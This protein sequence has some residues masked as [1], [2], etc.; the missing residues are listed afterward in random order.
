MPTVGTISI[1]LEARLAKLESQMDRAARI[2]DAAARRM[3]QVQTQAAKAAES[4]W[5]SASA[6]ITAAA[7]AMGGALLYAAQRAL[8]HADEMG[9]AARA[10][11]IAVEQYSALAYAAQL[12]GVS[13]DQ[14]AAS[15]R[16]FNRAIAEAQRGEGPARLFAALGVQV[17]GRSQLDVLR[18]LADALQRVPDP[19]QRAEAA[20]RLFGR[21]G[22]DL[23]PMLDSGAAGIDQL[24]AR[25]R[26]LGIVITE[27][28]AA[29]AELWQDTLDD[30][31]ARLRGVVVQSIEA[32]LP[33]LVAYAQALNETSAITDAAR[34][35]AQG[36]SYALL[37]IVT[38]AESVAAAVRT[39][40]AAIGAGVDVMLSAADVASL[41]VSRIAEAIFTDAT[42]SDALRAAS[43]DGAE[44]ADQAMK[45]AAV[46]VSAASDTVQEAVDRLQAA[47]QAL[48]GESEKA[49]ESTSRIGEQ[50]RA[51]RGPIIDLS[52]A[53][54]Q[55][56]RATVSSARSA[57]EWARRVGSM[58][59]RA[60]S[61][62]VDRVAKDMLELAIALEEAERAGRTEW[63]ERIRDAM[64]ELGSAVDDRLVADLERARH[65]I[66]S[67]VEE[68]EAER[69]LLGASA[70]AR[71]ELESSLRI[72]E[73]VRRA[74]AGLSEEQLSL[75]EAE[76]EKIRTLA[77]EIEALRDARGATLERAIGDAV[78]AGLESAS[79]E[80]FVRKLTEGVRRAFSRGAG[81]SRAS[82][83]ERI[84]G[85]VLQFAR[86]L[87]Q[88]VA[89]WRSAETGL[90]RVVA[91]ASLMPGPVGQV[92]QALQVIDAIFGGRLLGTRYQ[93]IGQ[94]QV[95]SL[96]AEGIGGQMID[97][98]ERQRSLFRGRR[99]REIARGLD[100][101]TAAQIQRVFD[102]IER[103]VGAAA[104]ALGVRVPVIV[105]G[106]IEQE[107]DKD[108]R[109]VRSVSTVLGRTYSE[110]VEEFSRR[111]TA[112]SL[113]ATLDRVLGGAATEVAERYR[114]S[115][116]D[117][118]DAAQTLV[119][120]QS[121]IA[122][123]AGLLRGEGGAIRTFE[124]VEALARLGEGLE[125]AYQRIAQAAAQ[126]EAGIAGIGILVERGRDSFVA[127][128]ASLA[129]LVG[130]ASE[131]G[132]LL[133]SAASLADPI[134]R[135]FGEMQLA[136]RRA[137]Q[138][139]AEIGIGED[140]VLAR[141]R[142]AIAAGDA[143]LA[144]QL[145]RVADAIAQ[146]RAAA[147][148]Y[149]EAIR[150]QRDLLTAY[151]EDVESI[152]LEL[153]A[154]GLSEAQ[155]AIADA[156]IAYLRM[157]ESLDRSARAAGLAGA[158]TEDL[159][160][161]QELY[162][163]RL[164]AIAARLRADA[165][166]IIR[167]L[168]I[169]PIGRLEREIAALQAQAEASASSVR[170]AGAAWRAAAEDAASAADLLRIGDLSPLSYEQRLEEALRLFRQ[171]PS[172]QL[173]RQVLE[174]A[175]VRFATGAEYAAIFAEVERLLRTSTTVVD[176]P[177]VE[178]GERAGQ[179]ISDRLAE[180]L[181]ERD[182]LLE[183]QQALERAARAQELV[184]IIA[185]I[186][187]ITGQ[188]IR[189]I[190]ESLG[191]T[192]EE[193]ADVLGVDAEAVE[194]LIEERVGATEASVDA[195]A[196]QTDALVETLLRLP[197]ETAIALWDRE[198]GTIARIA[199]QQAESDRRE[200]ERHEQTMDRLTRIEGIID[201]VITKLLEETSVYTERTAR[202]TEA[203]AAG[204]GR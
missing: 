126:L 94:R 165:A 170:S 8:A 121:D 10:A 161:A 5:A 120:I 12:A 15:M 50:A 184:G 13:Q 122:R 135:A 84:S 132:R 91:L 78:E 16:A 171:A 81:E 117:L 142:E 179:I 192:F 59:E 148:A 186:A 176:V 31:S 168:G 106:R 175:R 76:I 43:A 64:V 178:I 198:P 166:G 203:L 29:S 158:R 14:L 139:L 35:L 167:E 88:I 41:Y 103:S 104:A 65:A 92:A 124:V 54:A 199:D 73:E 151:A 26:E 86:G 134:T 47:L 105:S 97:I 123:G 157:V 72:E 85:N 108:R 109:L 23:L 79:I 101:E 173:A 68:L 162:A 102:E 146:A 204:G 159:S 20:M 66:R 149:E 62:R 137:Q 6:K 152:E 45:S 185:G 11:G 25:A 195:I 57:D 114:E 125:A 40:T 143:E 119:R 55:Q 180:L 32:V 116:S 7:A 71:R 58:V 183:Q 155:R 182:R 112:E 56:E 83:A 52:R 77:A 21:A 115:A 113:I 93:T 33:R 51:V 61:V 130:G 44:A 80:A 17:S 163:R 74:T 191:I 48:W 193:L 100:P 177:G 111:I 140:E 202:A 156:R 174:L 133:Q 188:S 95:I 153:L 99:R 164:Q 154:E 37:G 138:L 190:V 127:F 22:T 39:M 196:A 60:Q 145:L 169:G 110:S 160:R 9:E 42:L 172:E 147:E 90:G 141:L 34:G 181:A 118:L 38:V 46:A 131:L 53:L 144:A 128:A 107:W 30:V 98:Q 187:E 19:A 82:A 63:V 189:E 89:A 3:E 201:R 69:D 96:S 75:L 197:D 67:Y 70:S 2:V 27:E 28:A 49:A 200:E 136:Q 150:R 4:S 87:Q 24:M 1:D 194:R 36:L 129:D 18:D